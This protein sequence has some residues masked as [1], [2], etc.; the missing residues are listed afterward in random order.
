MNTELLYFF[1]THGVIHQTTC[2]YT[3]QQ[4]GRVERRHRTLLE[5]TRALKFQSYL[6]TI[7]MGGL[8]FD[9]NLSLEQIT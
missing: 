8:S 5:M 7:F 1:T 6:P 9:I 2:P 3:P 4:N